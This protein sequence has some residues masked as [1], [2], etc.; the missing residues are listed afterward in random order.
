[1]LV[2]RN[3]ISSMKF[4]KSQ[5]RSYPHQPTICSS[6]P[7]L[8]KSPCTKSQFPSPLPCPPPLPPVLNKFYKPLKTAFLVV[9]IAAV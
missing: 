4:K 2:T 3:L 1:M 5:T 8:E 9:V 6:F 7:H